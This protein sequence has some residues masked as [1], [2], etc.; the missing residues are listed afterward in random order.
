MQIQKDILYSCPIGVP[1][2]PGIATSAYECAH[3]AEHVPAGT[4]E[5]SR[6][7]LSKGLA[8]RE[9][10]L[11]RV[12]HPFSACP[13]VSLTLP[14]SGCKP[15]NTP[16]IQPGSMKD[17]ALA[18]KN[19]WSPSVHPP[20]SAEHKSES[21]PAACLLSSANDQDNQGNCNVKKFIQTVQ[22]SDNCNSKERDQ[23]GAS[24][25]F[26]TVGRA[27][28][29]LG[30]DY[31]KIKCGWLNCGTDDKHAMI[32]KALTQS[33]QQCHSPPSMVQKLRALKVGAKL[34]Y[35]LGFM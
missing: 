19:E 20:I 31:D 24:S 12:L 18:S 30:V 6:W 26:L 29:V 7:E 22:S 8:H 21:N 23:N 35:R 32:Q 9:T 17:M 27:F 14:W 4:N 3:S 13:Q 1:Q 28:E 34:T 15:R 33:P 5:V 25:T 11:D 16:L 2:D 10:D